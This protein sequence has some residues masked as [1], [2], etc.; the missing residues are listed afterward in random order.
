MIIAFHTPNL[1][2]RG[3]CVALRN[4][5]LYNETLL[6]NK[7]IIIT[8][9]NSI[10]DD[11][12]AFKWFHKRFPIFQYID[13]N[14]L[15]KIL[16][17]NNCDILY[18]IKYGNNDGIYSKYIKTVIHCVFDM[19]EPHGDIYAGVSKTLSTKFG[20]KC[21]VPHIVDQ[22]KHN[23]KYCRHYFRKKF[24]IQSNH[25]VFGRHGGIDT[26]NLEFAKKIISKIVRT[27]K[28]IYFIFINAPIWDTHPQII[29]LPPTTDSNEKL[30]FISACDAMIVP[31]TMGHTFG[32]SIGEFSVNNKPVICY[33]GLVWNTCHLDILGDKG[34]YFNTEDKLYDILTTFNPEKYKDKDLNAYKDFTPEKVMKQFK[35]VFID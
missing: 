25:I 22:N 4:Y 8:N 2:F 32:L 11:E 26:F 27:Y 17:T 31:E 6:N 18:C 15:E 16:Q 13:I 5:A 34:I 29:Y 7:S 35:Q 33:N 12:I 20:S 9:Y 3:S 30:Y 1:N 24:N 21:F 10:N 23:K 19:S 14:D 28:H